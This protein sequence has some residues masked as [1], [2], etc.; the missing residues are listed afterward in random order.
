MSLQP[1]GVTRLQNAAVATGNGNLLSTNDLASVSFQVTGTFVATVTF[2][3]TVD[4]ATW[5]G[6]SAAPLSGG[7][8][9]TTATTTGIYV[10]SCAGLSQV[11]ARVTWTSGTSVTVYAAAVQSSGA[12]GGTGVGV[13]GT[14]SAA[15]T[16]VQ[17]VVGGTVLAV[18]GGSPVIAAAADAIACDTFR[19]AALSNTAV[20]VKAAAA[21]L[22]GYS[23]YN[24]AAEITF[25]Q[26]YDVAQGSVTVG[27]T[28]PKITIPIQSGASETLDFG[29]GI[30]FGTALTVATTTTITGGTAP[31]T[32]ALCGLFYK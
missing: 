23:L 4:G 7:V 8:A 11:R 20:A 18:D 24:P 25:F 28:V 16:S 12:S 9:A 32:A 1:S 19:N 17:G 27:T 2:E 21:C 26:F 14:P 10:A 29:V 30:T 5:V 22:Y 3:G 6:L 13:A 31:A 15:V